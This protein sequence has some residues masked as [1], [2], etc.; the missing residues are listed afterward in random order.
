L[1]R[2][3]VKTCRTREFSMDRMCQLGGDKKEKWSVWNS[4]RPLWRVVCLI[5][6]TASGLGD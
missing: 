1:R 2:G 5:T 3:R 6:E 4:H